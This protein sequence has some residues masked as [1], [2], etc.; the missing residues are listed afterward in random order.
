M[1][2]GRGN[3]KKL[4]L[5]CICV[6]VPCSG[7]ELQVSLSVWIGEVMGDPNK[8]FG[9]FETRGGLQS[10]AA[11]GV[12]STSQGASWRISGVTSTS[13]FRDDPLDVME[14]SL[15]DASGTDC[16][17]DG[18]TTQLSRGAS[19]VTG[20]ALDVPGPF[21]PQAKTPTTPMEATGL[22]RTFT[23]NVEMIPSK[24]DKIRL[25]RCVRFR[26]AVVRIHDTHVNSSRPT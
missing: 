20:E 10:S 4:E 3:E 21:T 2:A 22:Q 23:L 7:V 5:D 1:E 11:S 17:T 13:K 9:R 19:V 18:N 16:G 25:G 24:D 15:C 8:G 12:D 14:R 26:H 6:T